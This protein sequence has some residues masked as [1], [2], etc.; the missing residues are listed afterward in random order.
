MCRVKG[1][2]G[3]CILSTVTLK[4]NPDRCALALMLTP[5]TKIELI[6][7]NLSNDYNL[8]MFKFCPI[9]VTYC[10][11]CVCGLVNFTFLGKRIISTDR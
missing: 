1:G 8:D 2:L 6:S 10:S 4:Y 7:V 3:T 5:V 11:I 9:S